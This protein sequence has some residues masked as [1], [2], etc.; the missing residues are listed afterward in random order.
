MKTFSLQEAIR[1]KQIIAFPDGPNLVNK[2]LQAARDDLTDAKDVLSLEKFKLATT[3][4]YYSIFHVCRALLYQKQYR[5]KSH[6]Q[7]GR[8]I[9]ALYVNKGLLPESF[10]DNFLQAFNLREIADYK[11]KFSKEGAQRNILDAQAT[12]EMAEAVLKIKL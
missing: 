8:A 7:L 4:A 3:C 1:R 5:E 2:E 6:I 9:K 12:L 11:N 10:Y